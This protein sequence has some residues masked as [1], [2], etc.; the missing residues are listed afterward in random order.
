LALKNKIVPVASTP[1]PLIQAS[2]RMTARWPAAEGSHPITKKSLT[3]RLEP[4]PPSAAAES[5]ILV[6]YLLFFD[7]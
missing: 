4:Q 6:R 7:F 2:D 5:S 1:P 3:H